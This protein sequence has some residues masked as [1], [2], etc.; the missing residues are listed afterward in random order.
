MKKIIITLTVLV[1]VFLSFQILQE[2]DKPTKIHNEQ[3]SQTFLSKHIPIIDI[4]T[5]K[6]WEKTGVIKDSTLL[7]FYGEDGRFDEQK[8]LRNLNANID[9]NSEFAILCRSGNRSNRVARFLKSKGYV[10]VINLTGGIKQGAKN[11]I[12][13]V[14]Y[15]G[16]F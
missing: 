10:K 15:I 6:E 9:K 1:S 3:L 12:E 8:F 2:D 7:T 14:N 4:R 11:H 5:K 13:L 16:H